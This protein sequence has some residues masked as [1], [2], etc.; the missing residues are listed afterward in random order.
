MFYPI[1]SPV[2]L[3][4]TVEIVLNVVIEGI[5][6][7]L[8]FGPIF[9]TMLILQD[10]LFGVFDT[11]GISA[12]DDSLLRFDLARIVS[13]DCYR[14]VSRFLDCNFEPPELFCTSYTAVFINLYITKLNNLGEVTIIIIEILFVREHIIRMVFKVLMHNP[15]G[16]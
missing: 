13:P 6:W 1:L 11:I 8:I 12:N 2:V 9:Y 16:Q 15:F 5:L 4:K 14:F 10:V 7:I 3:I